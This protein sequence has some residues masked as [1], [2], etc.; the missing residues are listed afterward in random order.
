MSRFGQCWFVSRSPERPSRRFL[1]P[2]SQKKA[3][4]VSFNVAGGGIEKSD[5][6]AMGLGAFVEAGGQ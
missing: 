3:E 4:P 1:D 6:P 5:T 2:F